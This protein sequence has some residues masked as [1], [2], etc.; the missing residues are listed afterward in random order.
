M[1]FE[2]PWQSQAFALA[3]T[4]QDRGVITEAEWSQA[5]G[6]EIAAAPDDPYYECWLRALERVVASLTDEDKLARYRDA[7]AHAAART[8]HGTPIELTPAD[9]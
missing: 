8:P 3:V 6:A 4:L 5:L 2:E 1:K 9:F 7:W